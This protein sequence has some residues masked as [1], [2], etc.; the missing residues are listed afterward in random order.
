[1]QTEEVILNVN[2]ILPTMY[3]IHATYWGTSVL[4]RYENIQLKIKSHNIEYPS[5]I[6]E[7]PPPVIQGA[8][9]TKP[10]G[11]TLIEYALIR[12]FLR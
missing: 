4:N 3:H 12:R 6:G 9:C 1:M 7:Y 11:I 10:R 8:Y 2:L 5:Q